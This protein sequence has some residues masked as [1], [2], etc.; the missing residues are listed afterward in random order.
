M[1]QRLVRAKRKIRAA[2]IPYEVPP[3]DLLPERLEAVMAV[4]YLIFNEGY[5]ATSGAALVRGDLCTEAIRLGRILS[6]LI[7]ENSEARGLLALMLLHDARRAARLD[8]NGD[9]ILLEEQDR[10]RWNS[11]Q[12]RE[13][14]V[15]TVAAM[16]P[17]PGPYAIQAAIAAAHARS[18][19][20][21][22]TDWREIAALYALLTRVQ[23]SPVVELNRAVA[24]A[25]ADGPENGLSLLDTLEA[26]GD[27]RDYHL[28]WS[29]RAD[30][31]RRLGRWHEAR[32]A[33]DHA[34]A[35][36]TGEPQRRFL[37]RRIAEIDSRERA[38][39]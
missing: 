29:A 33:Y 8:T 18:T 22:N 24:V 19:A 26:Q 6:E 1:A 37:R 11:A 3:D 27:L 13:G 28:L 12:I 2:R 10:A 34:L 32:V 16:S 31:L 35:L 20:A 23:P 17:A 15:L 30:L 25:M 38:T 4:V 39:R 9:L 14:L 5:S 21:A 7:A 36:V